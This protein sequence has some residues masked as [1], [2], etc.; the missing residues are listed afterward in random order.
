MLTILQY[1]ALLAAFF[2]PWTVGGAVKFHK[3]SD[4]RKRNL[5][6]IFTVVCVAILAVTLAIA[7]GVN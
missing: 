1:L 2:V 5:C 3:E 6:L 4:A 7:F